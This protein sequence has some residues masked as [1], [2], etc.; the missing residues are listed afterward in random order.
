M[1]PVSPKRADTHGQ[2]AEDDE[3]D[4][5]EQAVEPVHDVHGVHQAGDGDEGEQEGCQG[6][7]QRQ[8]EDDRVDH[9]QAQRFDAHAG[10]EVGQDA[11]HQRH[12]H[13]KAD[14]DGLADVFDQAERK[15]RQEADAQ[16]HGMQGFERR[17]SAGRSRVVQ[18][19]QPGDET[20]HDGQATDAGGGFGVELLRAAIRV[21]AGEVQ[22]E[23]AG[24]HQQPGHRRGGGESGAQRPQKFGKWLKA[25]VRWRSARWPA[26]RLP[27]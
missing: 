10:Q 19:H 17:Q 4:A 5:G 7:D 22:M 24:A 2:H 14:A 23:V 21:V 6:P 11:G 16:A 15:Q 13:A 8:A 26:R 25:H 12:P 20:G 27:Q 1:R 3:G 9:R 18:R